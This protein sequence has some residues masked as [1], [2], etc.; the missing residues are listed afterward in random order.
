MDVS[1]HAGQLW[2]SVHGGEPSMSSTQDSTNIVDI[3]DGICCFQDGHYALYVEV[4]SINV[5]LQSMADQLRI[6]DALR[7]FLDAVTQFSSSFVRP[8]TRLRTRWITYRNALRSR[9][10][11]V[12]QKYLLVY[13]QFIQERGPSAD[14]FDQYFYLVIPWHAGTLALLRRCCLW[15]RCRKVQPV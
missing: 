2:A 13:C 10:T 11:P 15:R 1:Q 5:G 9:R 6:Q 3:R 12:L 14:F 4:G 8:S 7:V